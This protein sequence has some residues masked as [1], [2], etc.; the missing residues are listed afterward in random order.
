MH[1]FVRDIFLIVVSIVKINE[2]CIV[3]RKKKKY[4]EK[5]MVIYD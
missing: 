3:N 1:D 2:I 4:Q 5:K